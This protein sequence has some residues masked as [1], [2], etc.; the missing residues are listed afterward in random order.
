M[1]TEIACHVS[2]FKVIKYVICG[3]ML[4]MA[5]IFDI[6]KLRTEH[7]RIAESFAALL[8]VYRF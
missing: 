7:T 4:R 6:Q 2:D 5:I 3:C 8:L 1:K